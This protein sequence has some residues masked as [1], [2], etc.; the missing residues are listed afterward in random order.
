MACRTE[1]VICKHRNA[2]RTYYVDLNDALPIGVTLVSATASTDDANLSV[3]SVGVVSG[4]TVIEGGTC[5]DITLKAN[6]AVLLALSGGVASVD[7]VLVTVSWTQS[8][9]DSDAVDCRLFVE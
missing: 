1:T 8:D 5:G 6:R 2:A 7:E 3:G 4:D 9:G